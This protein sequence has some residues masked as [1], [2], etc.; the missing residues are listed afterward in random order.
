MC[1][2]VKRITAFGSPNKLNSDARPV[3]ERARPIMPTAA[4]PRV[5]ASSHWN[6]VL[7]RRLEIF[8]TRLILAPRTMVFNP[9]VW[10]VDRSAESFVDIVSSIA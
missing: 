1:R 10:S 2:A 4:G 6:P 3:T 9:R 7:K 5:R 8:P